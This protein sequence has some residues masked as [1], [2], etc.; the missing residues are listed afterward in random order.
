MA[1]GTRQRRGA[2]PPAP[3]PPSVADLLNIIQQ[4]N[5][6]IVASNA[7]MQQLQQEAQAERLRLQQERNQAIADSQAIAND[8]AATEQAGG[9]YRYKN[10]APLDP[11]ERQFYTLLQNLG[12]D[13]PTT[14]ELFRQGINTTVCP[15]VPMNPILYQVRSVQVES[16]MIK[17]VHTLD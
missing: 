9:I 7:A 14:D 6:A 2:G 8:I 3:A 11:H 10:G 12:V 5:A 17:C 16:L 13:K 1:S 4:Q 15:W